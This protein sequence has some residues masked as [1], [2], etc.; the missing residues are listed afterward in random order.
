[1]QAQADLIYIHLQRGHMQPGREQVAPSCHQPATST[2]LDIWTFGMV[3]V[4]SP[5]CSLSNLVRKFKSNLRLTYLMDSVK[6]SGYFRGT[7]VSRA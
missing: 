2:C 1:M 3:L 7:A 4:L 5:V 6:S